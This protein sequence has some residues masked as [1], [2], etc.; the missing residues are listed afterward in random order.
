MK[1]LL[2]LN[3]LLLNHHRRGRSKLPKI[4]VGPHD[5]ECVRPLLYGKKVK[6]T[7]RKPL[8]VGSSDPL[9]YKYHS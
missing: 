2:F 9:R 8:K 7:R 3:I 1:I 5:H 6:N 4:V